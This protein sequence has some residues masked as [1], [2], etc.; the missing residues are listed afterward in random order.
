M[1][2]L[3]TMEGEASPGGPQRPE[4]ATAAPSDD[5]VTATASDACSLRAA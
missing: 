2:V 5:Q 1:S 4:H 3:L